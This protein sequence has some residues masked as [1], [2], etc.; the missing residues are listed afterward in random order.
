[1]D[2]EEDHRWTELKQGDWSLEMHR[3]AQRGQGVQS[4]PHS[5]AGPRGSGSETRER[6]RKGVLPALGE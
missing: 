4:P 3:Q 5:Q 2:G 6:G 1:M